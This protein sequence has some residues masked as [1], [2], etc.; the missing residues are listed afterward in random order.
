MFKEIA[1]KC[2]KLEG[3]NI[4]IMHADRL[5]PVNEEGYEIAIRTE[6]KTICEETLSKLRSMT[7]IKE[8]QTHPEGHGNDDLIVKASARTPLMLSL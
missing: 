6:G 1:E 4:V 7:C 5:G 3:L 2:P 8:S